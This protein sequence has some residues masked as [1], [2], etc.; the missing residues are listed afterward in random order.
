M[1]LEV[2]IK[3]LIISFLF[4][5]YFSYFIEINYKI[6]FKLKKIYK[7]LSSFLIVFINAIV[8]FIILMKINHG[9]IH[10]YCILSILL[11]TIFQHYLHFIIVKT[12]RK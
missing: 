1:I 2:Q 12:F 6:I 3:S 8:Y 4:G 9:I 7:I 11:G 5:I 10:P